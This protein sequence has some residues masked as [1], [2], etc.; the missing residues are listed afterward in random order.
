V[1]GVDIANAAFVALNGDGEVCLFTST[2]SH[3]VLDVV[4]Y[5]ST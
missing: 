2:T 4:A 1:S 5:T 3:F